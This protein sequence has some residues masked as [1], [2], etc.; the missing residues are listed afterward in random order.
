[1]S[2]MADMGSDCGGC[3]Y[4]LYRPEGTDY[5][6]C[7]VCPRWGEKVELCGES[8]RPYTTRWTGRVIGFEKGFVKV[9]WDHRPNA[10]MPGLVRHED[11]RPVDILQK[12][13]EL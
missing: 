12:L 1:M 4:R 2:K 10:N 11:L 7:G 5:L 8:A 13:A 9:Q 6:L 3:G